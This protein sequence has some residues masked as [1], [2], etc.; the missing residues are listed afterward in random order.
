MECHLSGV[1]TSV[2]GVEQAL[3]EIEATHDTYYIY[4]YLYI[5]LARA[6]CTAMWARSRS[7]NQCCLHEMV[8]EPKAINASLPFYAC[9]ALT[10]M[11]KYWFEALC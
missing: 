4:V 1:G 8:Y 5:Y 7:P 6:R 2:G 10:I 11:Y 3:F 9:A